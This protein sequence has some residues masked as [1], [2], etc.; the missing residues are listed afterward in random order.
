MSGR[1]FPNWIE[2]VVDFSGDIP[3]PLVFKRWSAISV[4]SG[5]L[6]RKCYFDFGSYQTTSAQYI[7][8]I[9]GSGSGKG[10]ALSLPINLMSHLSVPLG[11]NDA[12][13]KGWHSRWKQFGLKR[14]VLSMNGRATMQKLVVDM[15]GSA[16]N[17]MEL[18]TGRGLVPNFWDSSIN[19]ITREFGTF[20]QNNNQDLQDYLTDIWDLQPTYEYRTKTSGS[21]FV[22]GPSINWLAASTPSGMVK[23]MPPGAHD[24]G[25]TSRMVLIY[26]DGPS[27]ESNVYY[28]KVPDAELRF[29]IDDLARVGNL[30]GCFKMSDEADKALVA[31]WT[32]GGPPAPQDHITEYY[33]SRRLSHL[34][35]LCMALG[36]AKRDS[37]IIEMEDLIQG[38]ALLFESEAQVHKALGLFNKSFIGQV[39]DD[40][41]Q[42]VSKAGI[43]RTKLMVKII[44]RARTVNE[45]QTI[46]A[47]WE[48]A[49]IIKDNGGLIVRGTNYPVK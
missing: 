6:G 18:S 11:A 13:N 48:S 15:D 23:N 19:V 4:I 49:G 38:W 41:V 46:M 20:M 33:K 42:Y 37:K 30:V 36:A 2:A 45:A 1:H 12:T 35:K 34:I 7:T 26:Y 16:R 21:F 40:L 29:L 8:L 10:A 14:P 17:V 31:W 43:S 27:F 32:A 9:G 28:D 44:Q 25:L 47:A 5:M 24:H 22:K 3:A 39:T